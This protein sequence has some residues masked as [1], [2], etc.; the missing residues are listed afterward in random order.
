MDFAKSAFTTHILLGILVIVT[1]VAHVVLIIIL[2][3]V[4]AL[5]E[6]IIHLL[7]LKSLTGEPV[8]GAWDQLL[9]DVLTELIVELQTLLNVGLGVLVIILSWDCWW[10]EEVEEGLGWDG[11]LDNASLLGV[12]KMLVRILY[13]A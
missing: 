2:V 12:W 5:I 8:D 7:V 10:G 6:L 11:L 9:L 1:V 13:E 4:V 3:V